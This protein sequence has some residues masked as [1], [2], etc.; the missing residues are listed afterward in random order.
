LAKSCGDLFVRQLPDILSNL[1]GY[2][3]QD[4]DI[5]Y[6]NCCISSI[7]ELAEEIKQHIQPFAHEFFPKNLELLDPELDE[8]V[9]VNGLHCARLLVNYS[10]DVAKAFYQ[11]LWAALARLLVLSPEN[12]AEILDNSYALVCQMI[13]SNIDLCPLQEVCKLFFLESFS[14]ISIN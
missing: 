11:K 6:R 12:Y 2:L 14:F 4:M 3:R 5:E 1:G 13:I 9:L 7:A 8:H 10:G